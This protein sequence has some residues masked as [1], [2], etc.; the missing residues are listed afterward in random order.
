M[1]QAAACL[2]AVHL[3][4]ESLFVCVRTWYCELAAT[5]VRC[6]QLTAHSVQRTADQARSWRPIS[7]ISG[8]N[9][10]VAGLCRASLPRQPVMIVGLI[11]VQAREKE[12]KRG[13]QL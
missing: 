10:L 8:A 1:L 6:G 13:S 4:T 11:V 12:R 9:L 2:N 3:F 5:S 7:P